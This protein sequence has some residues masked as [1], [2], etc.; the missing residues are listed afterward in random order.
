MTVKVT[1]TAMVIGDGE[2]TNGGGDG[3]GYSLW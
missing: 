3:H 1:F 2:T